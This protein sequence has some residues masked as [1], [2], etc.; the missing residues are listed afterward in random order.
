MAIARPSTPAAFTGTC[1]AGLSVGDVVYVSGPARACSLVDI[2]D[3]AK[4]AAAGVIVR[5]AGTSCTVLCRGLTPSGVYAGALVP[6]APCFV[7]EDGRPSS[8]RPAGSEGALRWV[9]R[10]GTAVDADMLDVNVTAIT[11]ARS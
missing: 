10:V 6:G 1:P 11:G 8:V 7:G 2:T 4:V 3:R 5:K 9:V